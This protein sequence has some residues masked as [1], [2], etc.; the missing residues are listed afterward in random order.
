MGNYPVEV[1]YEED[2]RMFE[3]TRN[4]FSFGYNAKEFL[5]SYE[6]N[7]LNKYTEYIETK[8]ATLAKFEINDKISKNIY[9]A[10]ITSNFSNMSDTFVRN[11][12]KARTFV[13]CIKKHMD[14]LN[15]KLNNMKT[16]GEVDGEDREDEV[17]EEDKKM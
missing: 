15:E 11:I 10:V 3:I 7:G 13:I 1:H 4:R 14:E 9:D 12:N 2:D 6:E 16:M 5:K 17:D 8:K